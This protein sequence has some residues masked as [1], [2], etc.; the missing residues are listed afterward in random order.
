MKYI[1]NIAVIVQAR[2]GS[3]RCHNKMIRP[4]A[5]STL[6]DIALEKL[7][8]S[9]V[10]PESNIYLSAHE[11][12]LIS[13]GKKHKVNIFERSKKSANSEGTPMADMYEWWDK[14]P[15][16]YAV[17]VNA[18]APLL[19]VKTINDFVLKYS[20]TNSDGLFGVIEKKNYF[21]DE[22]RK[23]LTPLTEAVMNTKTAQKTYE[24]AHCLYAGRLDKIG[25]GVWMGNFNKPGDI[26]LFPIK[27]KEAFDI[28][29][30]WQFSA[31]E[32][33]YNVKLRKKANGPLALNYG[34]GRSSSTF[35]RY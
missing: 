21:W 30:E 27:E 1:D 20:N 23:F 35:E 6:T 31:C 29:H 14:I 7:V 32:A 4:F 8:A 11:A 25:D 12:E 2:L 5:D 19:S 18:C 16:E 34:V 26:E 17:L 3:Q 9:K 24:A 22:S 33:V 10:I 15:F 28:D 13:I